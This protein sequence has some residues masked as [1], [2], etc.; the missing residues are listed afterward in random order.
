MQLL[1]GGR[2]ALR[3]E[4]PGHRGVDGGRDR[5]TLRAAIGLPLLVPGQSR[6]EPSSTR[7]SHRTSPHCWR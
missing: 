6:P 7:S 4:G 2:L 1:L 5:A 3:L